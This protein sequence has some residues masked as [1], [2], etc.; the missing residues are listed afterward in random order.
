MSVPT[1]EAQAVK[2][3][4]HV[5]FIAHELDVEGRGNLW[6]RTYRARH[7][8]NRFSL[9][10]HVPPTYR[11][12]AHVARTQHIRMS[13]RLLTCRASKCQYRPSTI[14]ERLYQS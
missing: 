5:S 12:R 6:F 3:A 1:G 14:P 11:Y 2:A 9:L 13:S 8:T 10:F 7:D 4:M